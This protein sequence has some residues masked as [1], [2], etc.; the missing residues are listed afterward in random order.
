MYNCNKELFAFYDSKIRLSEEE[1]NSLRDARDLNVKRV[2][3][4]IDKINEEEAAEY[5]KF[6]Q[7]IDQGSMAM[8]TINQSQ[9]NDDQDI[10]HALIFE[11]DDL[12][13]DS[14]EAKE[15]IVKAMK[16]SGV[17]FSKDPE[18]R[19]N[20]VT[21]WYQD[22][23]H[24]DF[25]IYR[26]N[27][28]FWGDEILEHAGESWT[29]RDPSAITNWFNKKNIELSPDKDKN[30]DVT[31][32]KGQLRRVSRMFKYW[33]K[34]RSGWSLPGGLVLT[35]LIVEKYVPHNTRDDQ[36]FSDTLK[37]VKSRLYWDDDVVNPVDTSKSLVEKDHHKK[38]VTSLYKKLDKWLPTLEE[39]S[40]AGCDDKKA[41]S[42]WGKFFKN[43]WWTDEV[44]KA[45]D[46]SRISNSLARTDFLDVAV[47]ARDPRTGRRFKYDPQGKQ[48][49]PKGVDLQ[50]QAITQG[51]SG[52]RVEWEVQNDGDEAEWK[53]Q[54]D[55]RVGQVNKTNFHYCEEETAFKGDHLMICRLMAGNSKVAEKFIEVRVRD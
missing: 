41:K 9:H 55:P 27:E 47:M 51:V 19:T 53:G 33:S 21:V 39:L 48:T 12:P 43:T 15:H 8:H 16:K 36:S 20:A 30:K 24:V 6:V 18:A 4:G 28:D 52:Y 3:D 45:S 40:L 22:G 35:A 5:G 31:V 29:T 11:K 10:D 7:N 13:D 32:A 17:N 46:S 1:K 25:A 26:K 50:F 37:A 44:K 2:K 23:Y 42:L 38:Q 34:S 54:L 14:Q 49:L